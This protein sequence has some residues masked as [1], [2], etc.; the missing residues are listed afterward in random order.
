MKRTVFNA[1]LAGFLLVCFSLSSA[2]AQS[3]KL[4]YIDFQDLMQQMPEYSKAN[5]DMESYG[6]LLKDEL[7]KMTSEYEKKL[8][9]YQKDGPKM[10]DAIKEMKEKELRD[11]QQRIQSF[12]QSAQQDLRKKE[13][14]LL[15]PIIEKAKKAI[16]DVGKENNYYYIFD[17]SQGSPLIYKPEGEDVM[18]LVKKKLSITGMRKSEQPPAQQQGQPQQAQPVQ[19]KPAAKPSQKK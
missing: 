14:E 10:A 11:M 17:A 7:D 6:K 9:S 5:S 1:T 16:I 3:H 18:D 19:P 12:Q 2:N 15:K 13:E 4:G 8:D